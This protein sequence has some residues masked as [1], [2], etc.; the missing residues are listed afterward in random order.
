MAV[1]FVTGG[2]G[3]IGS[4]TCKALAEAGDTPVVIDNMSNGHE[5]A[6]NWGPLERGDIRD[7]AFLSQVFR[8]H[9]PQSVIHFA[10]LIQVGESV[11]RPEL[12]YDNNVVGTLTLLEAMRAHGV[13][14]IVFSSTCAIFGQP[15]PMPLTEDLPHRPINPYGASKSFIEQLLRDYAAAHGLRSAALRYFNAAG[16]DPSGRIGEAHEPESHLI[17]LAIA[18][19]QGLRPALQVFGDDYDTADGTCIRDYVHVDDLAD[20]HIRA[21]AWLTGEAGHHTFN[22][23]NGTGY[24]VRQVIDTVERVTGLTVPTI[25]A[26]RRAGD[27]PAL[28]GDSTKA[29]QVLGWQPR[30]AALDDIVE[31]AW[32][33]HGKATERSAGSRPTL[34]PVERND[35]N[36]LYRGT[37]KR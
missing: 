29:R 32:R 25:V 12:Y 35:R 33:W 7:A 1:V 10:G 36:R 15:E 28:V 22:L 26:P 2:A 24:S 11:R 37:P 13:G 9:R 18:A 5:W 23:G 4:H 19:A 14:C 16:A 21:L 27:P 17:P 34:P 8:H 30:F 3:Y 20:A 31:S 6:V